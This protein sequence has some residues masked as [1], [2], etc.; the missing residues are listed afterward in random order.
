MAGCA[1][2]TEIRRGAYAHEAR[3]SA[4]EAHGDYYRAARERAAAQ[5]QFDKARDRAEAEARWGVF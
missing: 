3:A 1:S 5:K 4:L 2:S